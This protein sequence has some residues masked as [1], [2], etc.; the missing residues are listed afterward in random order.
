MSLAMGLSPNFF[1]ISALMMT[2]AAA[3]SVV[4]E[5]L[6]AVTDPVV[7][8]REA[9]IPIVFDGVVVTRRRVDFV[10]WDATATLSL[11]TKAAKAIKPGK[12]C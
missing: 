5:E 12:S 11:E 6:P 2:L 9:E 8:W 10:I 4:W 7:Q 1:T 3:P